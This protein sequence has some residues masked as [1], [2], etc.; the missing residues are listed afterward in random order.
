MGLST[1]EAQ[2]SGL[3]VV[4]TMVGG[5]PEVV[6]DGQ[7]GLLVPPRDPP[8]LS[9]AIEKLL[10]RPD[11]RHSMGARARERATRRFGWERH[12]DLLTEVY[13][14]IVGARVGLALAEQRHG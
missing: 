7:T 13:E 2:A 12:V 14:R 10:D 9:G 5:I 4:G 3:P 11:L 8:A 1:I 6:V